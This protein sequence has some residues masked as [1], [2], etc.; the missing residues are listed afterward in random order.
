[1]QGQGC[2]LHNCLCKDRAADC[3]TVCARTGLQTAQLFVQG[4]GCRLHNCL[5][6]GRAADCTTVCA[7]AGLQTAQPSV[8]GQGCRL[9]NCLCRGMAADCTTVCART[10]LQTAQPSLQEGARY[11]YSVRTAEMGSGNQPAFHVM[12]TSSFP[13][14][15]G[16][17]CEGGHCPPCSAKVK[18]E[19]SH[20]FP[21]P[22]LLRKSK[23]KPLPLLHLDSFSFPRATKPK[24][25]IRK[26]WPS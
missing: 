19:C 20:I 16:Q 22:V 21:P 25:M 26:M 9:H 1:V 17:I 15:K 24:I 12:G 2:R 23:G 3:T 4:Q 6:R 8:Q 5:C 7:G 14:V 10:G 11:S 13:R 18:N